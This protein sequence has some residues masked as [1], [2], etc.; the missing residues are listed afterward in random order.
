MSAG[1]REALPCLPCLKATQNTEDAGPNLRKRPQHQRACS[2]LTTGLR[3][4]GSAGALPTGHLLK[5][6][7]KAARTAGSEGRLAFPMHAALQ[8]LVRALR[9]LQL[10]SGHIDPRRRALFQGLRCIRILFLAPEPPPALPP[11]PAPPP[12]PPPAPPLAR[13]DPQTLPPPPYSRSDSHLGLCTA[14]SHTFSSSLP[15]AKQRVALFG[16]PFQACFLLRHRLL[17]CQALHCP[18][19]V[20]LEPALSQC[21]GP[22]PASSQRPPAALGAS[23]WA[24]TQHGSRK[25][26]IYSYT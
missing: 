26:C 19:A 16:G 5:R 11:P 25:T 3:G 15:T 22:I 4:P 2:N 23:T 8:A 12:V 10:P 20:P 17:G 6:N 18:A 7:S 24:I 21:M 14:V 13:P 9:S 1:M